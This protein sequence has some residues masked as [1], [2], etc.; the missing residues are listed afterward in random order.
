MI[1]N[2]YIEEMKSKQKELMYYLI[3]PFFLLVIVYFEKYIWKTT[4][5]FGLD[6]TLE[7]DT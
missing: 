6:K 4:T 2:K 3:F 1:K 7:E 5:C